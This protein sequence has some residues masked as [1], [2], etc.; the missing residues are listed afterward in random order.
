[1]DCCRQIK[2]HLDSEPEEQTKNL[3]ARIKKQV[4]PPG[5]DIIQAD[6]APY[7][8]NKKE[9]YLLPKCIGRE[10]EISM[11][12]SCIEHTSTT[13]Q[14]QC[15]FISGDDG[16]GKSY[17]LT[18]A[19]EFA[20]Q[21]NMKTAKTRFFDIN[22]SHENGIREFLLNITNTSLLADSKEIPVYI[23]NQFFQHH[24]KYDHYLATLYSILDFQIP[25]RLLSK[26]ETLKPAARKLLMKT[27]IIEIVTKV[28]AKSPV[29]II[30]DDSQYMTAN[31]KLIALALINLTRNLP[32]IIVCVSN[33]KQDNAASDIKDVPVTT[34]KMVP[35]NKSQAQLIFP[36]IDD[37]QNT[38]L[39]YL[40]WLQ[41]TE[42]VTKTEYH[43]T[44][45]EIL[46]QI[47]LRLN[48]EERDALNIA[49]ILG[50]RFS[51]EVLNTL[52]D[53]PHFETTRLIKLGYLKSFGNILEFTHQI[54][55]LTLY[56]SLSI[57]LRTKLHYKAASYYL[58]GNAPL[59]AYHLEAAGSNDAAKAYLSAAI[60]TSNN[61][62]TDLALHYYEKAMD[63]A[64]D[65]NEKYFAARHKGDLLLES[66]RIAL[67]VQAYDQAQSFASNQHDQALAWMGMAVGLIERKQYTAAQSLLE[68]CEPILTKS[69]GHES[70][71]HIIP[72]KL[73]FYLAKTMAHLKL[74]DAAIRFNKIAFEH[75]KQAG[76]SY[77]QA[78]IALSLGE[79]EF[80]QLHLTRA[81]SNLSFALQLAREEQHNDLEVQVLITLAKTKLFKADF[82]G[83]ANDLEHAMNLAS[84]NEDH[85]SVL[86][87]LCVLCL[88]DFYKGKFSRLQ[89]HTELATELCSLIGSTDKN[90][91]IASYQLLAAY[92]TNNHHQLQRLIKEIKNSIDSRN[93]TSSYV[94]APIM[95]LTEKQAEDALAYLITT[96]NT[97]SHLDG[98]EALE[99]CFLSIEAAIHHQLW[100]IAIEIADKLILLINNEALHFFIMCAERVRILS[101]IAQDDMTEVTR[102]E[103][104]DIFASAKQFGLEIHLPAYEE[105]LNQLR[106]PIQV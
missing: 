79:I 80:R 70:P 77:W 81:Y 6:P 29:M 97:L 73:Y 12:C 106:D 42:A 30:L 62:K 13:K 11:I 54:I 7:I 19:S 51:T 33:Q 65:N 26:Y 25:K 53:N 67:A 39:L 14:G 50:L 98:P 63:C 55:Q 18:Q 17:F 41:R 84:M 95:A 102:T 94:L 99:C 24:P 20:I 15:I 100:D 43:R 82:L 2:K 22:Y 101:Q 93:I 86:E 103:L 59:H 3:Y 23:A 49:S 66:D 28:A 32:V 76:T 88:L 40:S 78:K 75:A 105:A 37:F 56:K 52:L 36:D 27:V 58:F 60:S 61:F 9:K 31:M 69:P 1:M 68:R 5:T 57:K 92:H 46:E 90:N 89:Q 71:E 85:Q 4:S 96:K 8:K 38:N 35:L 45:A 47:N 83:A 16:I 72:A 64:Q 104:V 48:E 91:H 21:L 10:S 44:L 74:A 34:I 87:N